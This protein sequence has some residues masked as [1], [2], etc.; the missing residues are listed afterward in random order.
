MLCDFMASHQLVQAF[1]LSNRCSFQFSGNTVN[2]TSV[3]RNIGGALC[4][5]TRRSS[6]TR[7]E[8]SSLNS[9]CKNPTCPYETKV[10]KRWRDRFS[11]AIMCGMV[12]EYLGLM[13]IYMHANPHTVLYVWGYPMPRTLYDIEVVSLISAYI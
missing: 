4:Y 10:R 7:C 11:R 1:R 3:S 8:C 5:G 6:S 9:T 12:R 13:R 2:S